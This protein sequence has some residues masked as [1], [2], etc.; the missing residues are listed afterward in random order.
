M[1]LSFSRAATT[2]AA[3]LAASPIMGIYLDIAPKANNTGIDGPHC[4]CYSGDGLPDLP[5]TKFCC[6]KS[7][8]NLT[9]DGGSCY[10]F[11][12]DGRFDHCVSVTEWRLMLRM[13]V[14][15]DSPTATL[16]VIRAEFYD[17]LSPTPKNYPKYPD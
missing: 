12:S 5:C 1:K 2:L 4:T 9:D 13:T 11:G 7:R 14:C 3:V 16:K 8:G 15:Q 17:G 6:G 10:N